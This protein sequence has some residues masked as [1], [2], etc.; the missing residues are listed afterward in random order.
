MRDL[1][2]FFRLLFHTVE[3][4]LTGWWANE[5]PR[6][7]AAV[8]FYTVF[9]LAPL[10]II[11]VAIAGA[12]FGAAAAQGQIVSHIEE[13]V[14]RDA[15]GVIQSILVSAR[16]SHSGWLAAVV[17]SIVLLVGATGV[18]TELQHDL[19]R[20]W[21]VRSPGSIKS[22]I[23]TRLISFFIV[24]GCGAVLIAALLVNAG[25]TIAVAYLGDTIPVI[26]F[27]FFLVNVVLPFAVITAL[28]A[29]FYKV[30]PDV[31]IGWA[32]A[33]VGALITALLFVLGNYL[34]SFYLSRGAIRSAYGAAGSFVVFLV[35]IYYSAQIFFFGAE[36]THAY[37]KAAGIRFAPLHGAVPV[38]GKE[39]R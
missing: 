23:R 38:D 25:L 24:L 33:W 13:L 12:V 4:A 15:A 2:L 26:D 31:S 22:V 19:N 18:F 6:L 32:A 28:F 36:V 14:G 35:W 34:L 10:V 20:V 9:S 3:D 7:A 29:M 5:A 8:A 30:L 1:L 37:T 21:G 39:K 16:A 11:A 17:S 27:F